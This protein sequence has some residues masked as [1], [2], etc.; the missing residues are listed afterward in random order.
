VG[1]NCIFLLKG[2][3]ILGAIASAVAKGNKELL[4]WI[5]TEVENLG[6]ENFIHTA[7][8]ATLESVYGPDYKEYLVIEGGKLQ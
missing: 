5:N 7:Y 4:D 2:T 3:S 1:A 8:D 6:K